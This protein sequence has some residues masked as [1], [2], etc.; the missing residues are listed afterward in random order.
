[1]Q[2]C[3]CDNLFTTFTFIP[4][5]IHTT[6]TK[7]ND[8]QSRG[9]SCTNFL[10]QNLYIKVPPKS[11]NIN[12]LSFPLVV[13]P[14]RIHHGY[15]GYSQKYKNG[16]INLQ[17]ECKVASKTVIEESHQMMIPS[18]IQSH[19]VKFRIASSY[20]HFFSPFGTTC[21]QPCYRTPDPWLIWRN[22]WFIHV[23]TH[24]LLKHSHRI[25]SS[26]LTCVSEEFNFDT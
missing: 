13:C 16:L 14:K 22:G 15:L 19:W 10:K 24:S 18:I 11:F 25:R 12:I 5:T 21:I 23:Q 4:K 20:M 9:V 7:G 6:N 1:M 2:F 8:Q 26:Q 17:L 3:L